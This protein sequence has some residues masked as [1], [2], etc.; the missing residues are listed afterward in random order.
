MDAKLAE[1]R[2]RVDGS[3]MS[4]LQWSAIA[5]CVLLNVADGFDVLV[6]SF[7]AV[8]VSDEWSLSSSQLGLLLSA[9]LA[10]MA[11]GS[12]ILAPLADRV[13]RRALILACLVIASAG[14][15]GSA[16]SQN[17]VQL[18]L[19]RVLTGIGVGGVLAASNVIAAEYA[20][21]RWRGLAA[22]LN[23]AGYAVGATAGGV[24]TVVLQACPAGDRCSSSAAPVRPCSSARCCGGF[25]SPW[26]FCSPSAHRAP[27]TVSTDCL[28]R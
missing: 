26:T 3:P 4:R 9:G 14:M 24:I 11:A 20:N 5:V 6:M 16:L 21:G 12:L 13:G 2:A 23:V 18:G 8:A 1:L 19:L 7:T 17:A 15:L 28:P 27:W 25:P 22:G 10:G